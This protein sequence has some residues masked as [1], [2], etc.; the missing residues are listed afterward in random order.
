M[1]RYFS[2]YYDLIMADV[3][4][5]EWIGYLQQL[6]EL[7]ET[8]VESVLE[9]GC[10]TGNVLLELERQL[11]FKLMVG[12]DESFEMVNRARNKALQC[13]SRCR[14]LV[15]RMQSFCLNRRFDLILCL[16]DTLNYL[17]DEH[18]LRQT[19]VNTYRSLSDRKL[20]IF[21][22]I[23]MRKL[24]NLFPGGSLGKDN[25]DWA[26]IWES[27]CLQLN[28]IYNIKSTFFQRSEG[29]TFFKHVEN[30]A[31]RIYT[32][33]ELKTVLTEMNFEILGI[34]DAYKF[35]IPDERSERVF[36]LCRKGGF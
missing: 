3:E 10:G 26:Y 32:I 18:S 13:D 36:F 20:L 12:L 15:S 7:S 11:D 23:T 19:L 8:K 34:Y 31:K 16:F 25:G 28:K 21:D 35:K 2:E 1:Y 24:Q 33:D 22:T 6:I 17:I 4:Y 5:E 30:H 27:Q 9:L 14:F 29:K